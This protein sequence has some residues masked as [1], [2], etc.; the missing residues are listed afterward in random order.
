MMMVMVMMDVVEKVAEMLT[1][2]K[3]AGMSCHRGVMVVCL[4]LAPR[5]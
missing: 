4:I 2:A 5:I 3:K 1:F